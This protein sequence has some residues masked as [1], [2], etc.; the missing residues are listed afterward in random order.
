MSGVWDRDEAA[1]FVETVFG[2]HQGE[3]YAYLLRMMRDPEVAADMTQDT[4]IKAYK[5][6][7][8]LEKPENA[9]AW[10]Y[11]IAHRVALDEIRR[12]KIVRFLPWTGEAPRVGAVRRAPGDGRAAVG[13]P[14]ACPRSGSRNGS[15]PRSSSRSCTT[16]PVSSWRRRSVSA[17]SRPERSSRALAKAC[18]R[19]L[20]PNASPT[21]PPIEPAMRDTIRASP[22]RPTDEP[23]PEAPPA[24]RSLARRPRTGTGPRR[25]AAR[26]P[27]GP[28]RDGLARRAPCRLRVL[29]RD[30]RRLRRGSRGAAVAASRRRPSRRATCGRARQPRSSSCRSTAARRSRPSSTS[31]AVRDAAAREPAAR[32]DVGG[33]GRGHR[34][35]RDASCRAGSARQTMARRLRASV[36]TA[37]ATMRPSPA[38]PGAEQR[39]S[40]SGRAT[41]SGSTPDT[42]ASRTRPTR[43][44]RSA[45][46]KARRTVQRS[47]IR[48]P[49]RSRLRNTPRTVIGSP[50]RRQAVAI[51]KTADAATRS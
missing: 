2:K 41:S 36:G 46:R 14:A 8:T 19:H 49:P 16:S 10:L 34:R 29:C 23:F 28:D 24:T 20:P 18:A 44:S 21:P 45:R 17:T 30:R 33:G 6:Y 1:I 35:R 4:F 38:L 26:W 7:A 47:R 11:Q 15:A 50:S 31:R 43:S 9:R 13:R 5:N 25:R 39:R 48:P 51:S 3:I 27:A 37:D 12:R 32:R 42:G 40:P 22:R